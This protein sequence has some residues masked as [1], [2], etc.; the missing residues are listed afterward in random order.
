MASFVPT[1]DE[2]L[3]DQHRYT[4]E[5]LTEVSCETC[6]ATVLVKKNSEHHTSVQWSGDALQTCQEFQGRDSSPAR[7]D[8][9]KPCSRMMTSIDDAVRA[10][11]ILIGAYD[12]Y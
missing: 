5:R 11:D 7:R 4:A 9:H 2:T 8:V 3:A 6:A 12:G 10:G 1:S